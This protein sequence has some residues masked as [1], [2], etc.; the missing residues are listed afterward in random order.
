M[1]LTANTTAIGVYLIQTTDSAPIAWSI[2]GGPEKRDDLWAGWGRAACTC[3]TFSW[4]PACR[5]GTMS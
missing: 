4:R 3:A 2:D 1:P 5:A